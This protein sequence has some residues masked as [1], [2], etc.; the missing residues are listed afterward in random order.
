MPCE[1]LSGGIVAS[2]RRKR[3]ALCR[4]ERPPKW[5][6]HLDRGNKRKSYISKSTDL[7]T[8]QQHYDETPIAVKH[9]VKEKFLAATVGNCR[10]VGSTEAAG[11]LETGD[12]S[13]EYILTGRLECFSANHPRQRP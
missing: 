7:L 8:M 10:W 5:P 1:Q 3:V 4:W 2:N 9:F 11:H 12:K 6:S 13:G